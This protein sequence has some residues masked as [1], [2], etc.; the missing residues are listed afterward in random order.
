MPAKVIS[1]RLGTMVVEP[2]SLS[3]SSTEHTIIQRDGATGALQGRQERPPGSA[4][5]EWRQC[6]ASYSALMGKRASEGCSCGIRG[7]VDLV[8]CSNRFHGAG[9]G[10]SRDGQLQP[11]S[12]AMTWICG[13]ER[14]LGHVPVLVHS[15]EPP[16][17]REAISLCRRCEPQGWGVRNDWLRRPR[18]GRQRRRFPGNRRACHP[19]WG[20]REALS[21]PH[22]ISTQAKAAPFVG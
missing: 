12:T 4:C 13:G 17:A 10:G 2:C 16:A 3:E 8:E 15:W 18:S 5:E 6:A 22:G 14:N 21:D 7:P 20:M 9:L 1:P 11:P 19:V